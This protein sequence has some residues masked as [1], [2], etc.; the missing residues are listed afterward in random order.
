MDAGEHDTELVPAQ[1]RQRVHVAN[2]SGKPLGKGDQQPVT[3]GVAQGVIDLLEPVEVDHRDRAGSLLGCL[4]DGA[5]RPVGEL[6]AVRHARQRVVLRQVCVDGRLVAKATG[7]RRR[8]SQQRGPQDEQPHD[9]SSA[10]PGLAAGD[11]GLD[12]G[13]GQV[14]LE[15][16]DHPV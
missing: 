15:D 9:E 5:L 10:Q 3:V 14:D 4:R 8:H 11:V 1:P 2:S 6:R 13:V 7:Q 16:A 12:R